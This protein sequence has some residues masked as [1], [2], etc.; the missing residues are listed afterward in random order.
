VDRLRLLQEP[1][2][3]SAA[4]EGWPADVTSDELPKKIASLDRLDILINNAGG[5]RPQPFV[6]VD[7]DSLDFVI[8]LN[9]R[10]AFRVAQASRLSS[11]AGGRAHDVGLPLAGQHCEY[12]VANGPCWFTESL[13]LLHDQARNRRAYKGDGR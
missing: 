6:D 13:G 9:V 8:D 1:G 2:A 12:V 4:V 5:N 3:E 10:A 7:N 11:G